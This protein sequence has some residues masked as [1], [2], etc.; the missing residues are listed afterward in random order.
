[1]TSFL[2]LLFIFQTV[3]FAEVD[4]SQTASLPFDHSEW[5][6][7]LKKFVNEK[8]EVNYQRVWQEQALLNAY[9]E[10]LKLIPGDTFKNWPREEKIAVFIN[11]YNANV[12]KIII[13]HYPVKTISSIPGIWD[14]TVIKIG[15][16]GKGEPQLFSLNRI[17]NDIL[18]FQFRDEKILF[19]L[20]SGAKD[21]PRLRQDAYT[22]PQLEGQ[23]Y[24]A[25]KEFVNDLDKNQIQVG[26]K[27]IVLSRLFKWYESDF[28]LNWSNFPGEVKWRPEEMAAMSFVA[29]Y[30]EDPKK[31]EYLEETDY[32]I[33]YHV[34]NW[35]LNDW[36]V[37]KTNS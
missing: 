13:D 6:Q 30:L 37:G 17:Q 19:A 34:F 27:K 16:V 1:M 22:G 15:T 5:D 25:A 18:R 23:L 20:S 32:K 33:K 26:E 29:H 3:L 21:S 11:A 28:L 35:T 10:K 2:F 7:F 4:Q 31:V 14:R 24:L 8:G 9:L 36:Q 12:I